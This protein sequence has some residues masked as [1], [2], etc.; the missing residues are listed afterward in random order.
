MYCRI[1][2]NT[3]FIRVLSV[4]DIR[5]QTSNKYFDV[6]RCEI[7]GVFVT[8]EG[9]D[10]VDPDIY[11][12]SSYGAF[13]EKPT[14]QRESRKGF[15]FSKRFILLPKSAQ[16]GRSSWVQMVDICPETRI[17]D[18]GCGTGRMGNDLEETF[19][20]KVFGIEPN[21]SAAQLAR[22]KGMRVHTGVLGDFNCGERFDLVLLIHVLEHLVDPVSDLRRIHQLLKPTGKLVI[23]VP[24][25]NAL[26]RKIF[27][28]YWDGWDIPRHVQHFSSESLR[29]I[30][31]K[32]GFDAGRVY[33]ERYSLFSRSLANKLFQDL[34]YHQRKNKCK[35][36][37]FEKF[38]SIVQP[39]LKS[40]SAMQVIAARS[41]SS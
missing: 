15:Q 25:V 12:N 5:Y 20:C 26:E 33:Y 10:I 36:V 16:I 34:P 11:Y 9:N 2:N 39:L 21:E 7:C 29:Y 13:V 28:K 38:W 35:F 4:P 19:S 8:C 24:N 6:L 18:I 3:V 41:C 17:L 14:E 30:L 27:A 22:N 31:E 37:Y 1:C 40:S 32:T 23:A